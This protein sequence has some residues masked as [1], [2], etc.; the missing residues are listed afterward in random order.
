MDFAHLVHALKRIL[1][2]PLLHFFA[3]GLALFALYFAVGE[4]GREPDTIVVGE[5]QV[6]TLRATFERTWSRAPSAEELRGLIDSHVREEIY[7]REGLALGLDRDDP[8]IRRRVRQKLEFFDESIRGVP[9]PD[10]AQLQDYLDQHR[11]RYQADA[12]YTFEQ[13]YLGPDR[14]TTLDARM[15]MATSTDVARAFG[16]RF[17]VA[18]SAM[19]AGAWREPVI[20]A[21]GPHRVLVLAS[22]PARVPALDEVRP[23]V[24]RDWQRDALEAASEQHYAELRARYEVRIEAPVAGP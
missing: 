23:Q 22:E 8:L 1:A 13:V 5:S 11:D 6:A 18:L 9:E 4:G 7:Y 14:L 19:P 15:D 20:S 3:L 12:R 17:A 16:E 10:D 2:E 24:K 21:Y